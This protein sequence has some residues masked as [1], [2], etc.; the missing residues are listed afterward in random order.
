MN[1]IR[2]TDEY[3]LEKLIKHEWNMWEFIMHTYSARECNPKTNKNLFPTDKGR[4]KEYNIPYKIIIPYLK[5][6]IE[7]EK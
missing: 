7:V 2:Y 6:C 5:D 4:L 1:F 3:S